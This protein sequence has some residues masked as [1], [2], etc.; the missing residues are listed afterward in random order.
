MV[1][2]AWREAYHFAK[3]GKDNEFLRQLVSDRLYFRRKDGEIT[4]ETEEKILSFLG[5]SRSS[6]YI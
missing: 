2:E 1:R 6:L 5:L 4:Q 3:F